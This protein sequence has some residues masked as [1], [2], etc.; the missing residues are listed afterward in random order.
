MKPVSQESIN[1][2]LLRPALVHAAVSDN[3]T[4]GVTADPLW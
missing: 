2:Q 4:E 1:E 3:I